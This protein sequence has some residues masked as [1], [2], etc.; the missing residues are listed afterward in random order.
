MIPITPETAL[1]TTNPYRS[2]AEI[3]GIAPPR[4]GP[5]RTACAVMCGLSLLW[6]VPILALIPVIAVGFL[7]TWLSGNGSWG[8]GAEEFRFAITI[9]MLAA[10]SFFGFTATYRFG[11]EKLADGNG[12]LAVSIFT[13]IAAAFLL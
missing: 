11:Q 1:S 7:L 12:H 2:P 9:L 10:A 4:W 6:A 3:A 8:V 13:A 5:R